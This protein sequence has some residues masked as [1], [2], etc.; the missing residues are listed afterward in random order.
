MWHLGLA[1]AEAIYLRM[2]LRELCHPASGPTFMGEDNDA[3]FSIATTTQTSFRTRHIRIE[4]HFIRDA[5][6]NG[7]IHLEHVPSADNPA[8]MMTKPLRGAAFVRHR[9]RLLSVHEP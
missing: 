4:F 5:I 6:T 8:D 3:C 2:L 7:E 1:T 9:A